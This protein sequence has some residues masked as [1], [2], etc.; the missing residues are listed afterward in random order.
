SESEIATAA[1]G[2][3]G[4]T[5]LAPELVRALQHESQ[6]LPGSLVRI[7]EHYVEDRVLSIGPDG[8]LVVDDERR[9][10]LPHPAAA[11]E[12]L[13]ARLRHRG[14]LSIVP[15]DLSFDLAR[16][17]AACAA[18]WERAETRDED[19]TLATDALTDDLAALAGAQ[20]LVAR[21]RAGETVYEFVSPKT[22][23]L[24]AAALTDAQRH[25]LHDVAAAFLESRL[26]ER[27]DLIS[28]AATHA[29]KGI[30]PERG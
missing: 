4:Q 13:D 5:E 15:T 23:E 10:R 24:V 20:L 21:E 18:R 12:L 1:S 27:P 8:A 9:R 3:L 14:A 11:A 22:R 16:R 26:K 2:A 6:G 19:E 30:D 29:L 17:L 28:A 25:E 7:L